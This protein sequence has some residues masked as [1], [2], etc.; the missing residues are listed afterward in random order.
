MRGEWIEIALSPQ[1]H[2]GVMSLPM[3]GEWIEI[4][5]ISPFALIR[6]GLSPCGEGGLK[7][8]ERV[9]PGAMPPSLPMR[10]EWIEISR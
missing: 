8:I 5:T 10:G 6:T 9:E 2:R 7:Y 4:K 1:Y 3:R